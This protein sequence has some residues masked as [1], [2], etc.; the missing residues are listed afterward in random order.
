MV[1]NVAAKLAPLLEAQG[2]RVFL[3]RTQENPWRY[4]T[5]RHSDN[6][7][8]AIFAN[9]MRADVYVRLHCDWN[10]NKRFKGF[11]TYYFRWGSRRL[12]KNIDHALAQALPEHKN[13]GLHRRAFVSITSRMPAVLLEMGVLSNKQEGK[14]L[15]TD[16]FQSRLAEAISTGLV[17]YFQGS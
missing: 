1:L 3:T 10:R 17:N 15:S 8:R 16:A 5:G 7:A 2:A 9:V 4:S 6:R 13:R 11:T 14:D 12:A